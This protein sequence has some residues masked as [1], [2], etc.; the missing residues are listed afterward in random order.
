MGVAAGRGR[1]PVPGVPSPPPRHRLFPLGD[2]VRGV[3]ALAVVTVHVWLFTGGFGGFDGSL[4][5][6]LVV[7]LDGMVSI[8][9]VLSAFLLY[10]PMIAYRAGGPRAPAVGGYA[11]RRFLR[12]YPAYWLALTALA[13]F[14]G[15]F[16]VFTD[17]WPAFYSLA[18]NLDPLYNT[19]VCPAAD[20]F[21][22]GLPQS[23]TLT[24]EM[25]FYILLPF[26]AALTA[27]LARG[28]EQ[29]KWVQVELGILV[30]LACLSVFLNMSPAS[31][32]DEPWFRFTFAGHFFWIA[33]GLAMAVLSVVYQ[34]RSELPQPLRLIAQR[35]GLSWAAAVGVYLVTVVALDP[36]P[37]IVADDTTPQFL[38]THLAH[39]L[40][41]TLIMV[42]VVFGDPNATLPRRVLA[43]PVIAWIGLVSYGLYLWQVTIAYYLGFGGAEAGFVAVLL[44][45]LLVSLPLAALSYYLLERPLM[46]LKHRP[47]REILGLRRKSA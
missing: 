46:R 10:R 30:A 15:L 13:I 19:D 17:E 36:V 1:P 47:F 3:A 42:P 18:V 44:L 16:G 12:I 28:R 21:A 2:G 35:P 6:R 4:P 8:F 34:Q 5:N 43:N 38:A 20:A 11:R 41:A 33:L 37:F 40:L 24:T 25:S 31:L 22:C 39:G 45:T 9:F 26:Y 7:R 32:R 23:W 14:P 29:R 27:R